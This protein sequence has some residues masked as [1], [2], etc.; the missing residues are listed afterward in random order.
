MGLRRLIIP[1]SALI[2]AWL[3]ALSGWHIAVSRTG[4]PA[5]MALFAMTVSLWAMLH[6]LASRDRRWWATAGLAFAVYTAANLAPRAFSHHSWYKE[7]FADYPPT[8]K[9]LIPFVL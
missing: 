8:R 9:A 5:S 3:L 6:A 2:G 1:E 7:R 4:L